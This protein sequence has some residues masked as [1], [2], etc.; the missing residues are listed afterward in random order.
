MTQ[1]EHLE[2]ICVANP[3]AV[4]IGSLGSIST[5]LKDIPHE[6]KVLI[7]GA[8]GAA[9]GCGLGYALNS[10]KNVI[11]VIGDGSFLMSMGAISTILKYSPI[12]LRVIVMNNQCYASC[13]GQKTYFDTIKNLLPW[14]FEIYEL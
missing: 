12:N 10:S 2:K 6:N 9:L 3:R 13:G 11:V 8:M 4:I 14:M 7:K 5:D 1:K